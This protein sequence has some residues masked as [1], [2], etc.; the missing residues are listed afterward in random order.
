MDEPNLY[1]LV[2]NIIWQMQKSH[3]QW[4]IFKLLYLHN[5]YLNNKVI[6]LYG[7]NFKYINLHVPAGGHNVMTFNLYTFMP[8]GV[9]IVEHYYNT[10][11]P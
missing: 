2:V 4:P 11:R 3:I 9:H 6:R 10:T 1:T 5:I 8:T 7:I